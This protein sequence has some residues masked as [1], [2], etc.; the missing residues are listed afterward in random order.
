MA[1]ADGDVIQKN[2]IELILSK[3]T[4]DDMSCDDIM[5]AIMFNNAF[6]T[7]GASVNNIKDMVNKAYKNKSF[8]NKD[9]SQAMQELLCNNGA[10]ADSIIKTAVLQKL[11]SGLGVSPDDVAKLF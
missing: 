7:N 10:T 6:D 5:K 9:L 3:I 4:S 11:L 1:E 8:D 2:L